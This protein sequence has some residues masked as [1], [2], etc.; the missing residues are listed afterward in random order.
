MDRDE[1]YVVCDEINENSLLY[2]GEDDNSKEN[3]GGGDGQENA[4]DGKAVSEKVK[5]LEK[6]HYSQ[7]KP[8]E[9]S[10][11]N[12]KIELGG[13]PKYYPLSQLKK[14]LNA[15]LQL[16]P[17]RVKPGGMGRNVAYVNFKDAETRF[18]AITILNGYKWQGCTLSAK[19]ADPTKDPMLLAK[20]DYLKVPKKE[21]EML[22]L[23][24]RI[25]KSVTPYHEMSYDDQIKEK[26]K[27]VKSVLR[28]FGNELASLNPELKKFVHWHKMRLDDFVHSPVKQAYR[29]K[30]EFTIESDKPIVGFRVA[31]YREGSVEVGPVDHLTH[32][33]DKMK[34]V[35]KYM[36]S[37][38]E[39]S[40][41]APFDP[42]SHNGVWRQ[43]AV[44]TSQNFDVMLIVQ[45]HPQSLSEDEIN[46]IK[47]D[48][49]KYF[50]EGEGGAVGVTSIFF[51]RVGQ[52]EAGK[53]VEFEH[54]YGKTYIEET[55]L[56][57]TFRASPDA[58]LQVNT[59]ACEVLYEKI[60]E[61]ADIDS[62]SIV[63][64]VCCGV[65]TIGL[66][67]AEHS[68]KTMGVEITESAVENA[69]RNAENNGIANAVFYNG[70]AEDYIDNMIERSQRN[71]VVAIVDPPRAGL[72]GGVM[73]AL[74][75][76]EYLNKIVYVSCDP[77]A[78]LP[79]FQALGRPRS[80]SYKGFYFVPIRATPV[81]LFPDTPHFELI[82]VF[83]RYD[84][85][86]WE[87]IMS[88]NPRPK[89]QE[90]FDRIPQLSQETREFHKELEEKRRKESR[91]DRRRRNKGGREDRGSF[92]R[93]GGGA[94]NR[95]G[96]GGGDYGDYEEEEADEEWDNYGGRRGGGG[97]RNSSNWKSGGMLGGWNSGGGGG[98]SGIGNVP[99]LLDGW[100]GRLGGGGRSAVPG[101][102]P[103]IS[104]RLSAGPIA[105]GPRGRGGGG[106]GG[107]GMR[108]FGGNEY[109]EGFQEGFQAGLGSSG[110]STLGFWPRRWLEY[111]PIS[112]GF[113]SGRR[114]R[115]G[116]GGGELQYEYERDSWPMWMG[117][118]WKQSEQQQPWWEHE[119]NGNWTNERGS[120]FF[121][122]LS[123]SS[124]QPTSNISTQRNK[125]A[126]G[127][128]V[129]RVEPG[130]NL[131][132]WDD[133]LQEE[134]EKNSLFIHAKMRFTII[135]KKYWES[136]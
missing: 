132:I 52:R 107:G 95:R 121:G 124:Q 111:G 46:D 13:L 16:D 5:E 109:G 96:F 3:D 41:H 34:E 57:K 81:D 26:D 98:R 25:Q 31:S 50:T 30:C 49:K 80:K 56:G 61:V 4:G 70:K 97:G 93:G 128:R 75:K 90:Y 108:N 99:P 35:V 116:G 130:R 79:N 114:F 66:S 100:S 15:S 102:N 47:E 67:I 91:D 72:G 134:E 53:E 77:Q 45:I 86:K 82:I 123:P 48:V 14:L 20:I 58:F 87:R 85:C 10:S 44:R 71:N 18:K 62:T 21:Y 133:D 17:H 104:A 51:Q 36:E 135:S 64:D 33:N 117:L 12:F 2:E 105:G 23:K 28:K 126:R 32:L 65:G 88:G 78:A 6:E 42:F 113:W 29:N 122:V 43:L 136:K 69:R 118:H 39:T 59:P 103:G 7:N 94:G 68:Y 74:R 19:E 129:R 27:V 22:P 54:V 112:R 73:N 106:S 127:A 1:D 120:G 24:D 89:D 11:E 119:W 63:L 76:C 8:D 38:L 131:H 125:S 101:L 55:I 37:Y 60:A 9:F 110:Q 84:E 40:E 92:G 115:G 83:E